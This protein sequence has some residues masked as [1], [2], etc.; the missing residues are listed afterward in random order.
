[1]GALP[2]QRCPAKQFGLIQWGIETTS[3]GD[4]L[5]LHWQE[6]GGPPARLTA[7]PQRVRLAGD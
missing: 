4:R 7:I 6:K 2:D 1:V 3:E 5:I